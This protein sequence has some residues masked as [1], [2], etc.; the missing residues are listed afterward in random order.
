[1][2]ADHFPTPQPAAPCPQEMKQINNAG[3]DM[4]FISLPAI[5]IH[6]NSHMMMLDNNNL[7]VAD[8]I[9]KWIDKHVKGE[10]ERNSFQ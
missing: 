3:G 5:G 10:K 4:T 8:V 6:G 2:V 7:E 1:V 9:I